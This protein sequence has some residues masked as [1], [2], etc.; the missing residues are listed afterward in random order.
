VVVRGAGD[1]GALAP[2]RDGRATP[3]DQSSQAVA[4]LVGARPGERVLDAAA[5]P[6]GKAGAIAEHMHD[7]GLVVAADASH[8]RVRMLARAA[9]RRGM[10]SIMPVIADARLPCV[11]SEAFDRVL[12]DAPCSGLGVL[13][14]RPDARWRVQPRDVTVLA[15]LQ[16]TMLLATAAAVRPGGRLVYAVC[17]LTDA[18]TRA[19][20]AFAGSA[21]PEFVPLARPPAPWRPHGR[22]AIVLPSDAG[23]DGM[24]VLVLE[25]GR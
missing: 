15:D 21:L 19:I 17:T 22:G 8:G 4:A 11:R 20:D 1:T 16:R 6:G 18:E 12:L 25:R 14:R 24:F 3:Q 2:V 10:Q 13:R 9:R 23:T 7:V 5:A